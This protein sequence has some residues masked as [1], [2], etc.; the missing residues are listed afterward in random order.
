MEDQ[1]KVCPNCSA[2]ISYDTEICP[3]CNAYLGA[4]K[5]DDFSQLTT[6]T[7]A[8]ESSAPVE[9]SAEIPDGADNTAEPVKESVETLAADSLPDPFFVDA[10]EQKEDAPVAETAEL[11]R[12]SAPAQGVNSSNQ[13]AKWI[14]IAVA[15]VIVLLL[16]CCGLMATVAVLFNA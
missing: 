4:L 11:P 8:V 6:D 15:A 10:D 3:S 9:E 13:T 5:A 12:T 7:P 2:E 1:K 16:C 14:W